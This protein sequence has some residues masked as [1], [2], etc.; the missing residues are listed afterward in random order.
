MIAR[1]HTAVKLWSIILLLMCAMELD[2]DDFTIRLILYVVSP[3]PWI[4]LLQGR[5]TQRYQQLRETAPKILNV[6][7]QLLRE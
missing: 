6:R 1:I 4:M 7:R 2:A 3:Q 5:G